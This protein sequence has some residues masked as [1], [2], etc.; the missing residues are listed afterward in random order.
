[1]T[2]EE[3]DS[4]VTATIQPSTE[5]TLVETYETGSPASATVTVAN[6]D[7][8]N[9]E[10]R[11]LE[12]RGVSAPH[13][14]GHGIECSQ[15]VGSSHVRTPE[16]M[17][18]RG[19][20]PVGIKQPEVGDIIA[21]EGLPSDWVINV[22]GEKVDAAV[23]TVTAG[24]SPVTEGTNVMFTVTR[25]TAAATHLS[26]TVGVAETQRMIFNGVP[27]GIDSVRWPTRVDILA[28]ATDA[29]FLVVTDDD[30]VD[31]ADSVI[32]ATV[33]AGNGYTVGTSGSAYRL[34]ADVDTALE[35]Q[36]LDLSQRQ[37][38]ADI[39]HHREADDFGRTVEVAEG[40]SHL[41]KLWM[42]HLR[43]NPFLSD[44]A[45]APPRSS[46]KRPR[47][48][49]EPA[50]RGA[51]HAMARGPAMACNQRANPGRAVLPV[52]R[53][54]RHARSDR[55]GTRERD[56]GNPPLHLD[57]RPR[58][59]HEVGGNRTRHGNRRSRRRGS[60]GLSGSIPALRRDGCVTVMRP[61]SSSPVTAEPT[62]S[63][64]CALWH[65]GALPDQARA[66]C[67]QHVLL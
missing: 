30:D 54:G 34:M 65:E 10:R 7:V 21:M 27:A 62:G 51:R 24:T 29:T 9:F 3:R 40:I 58:C 37:W 52:R 23:V 5:T 50:A 16:E 15:L 4:V 63:R 42:P 46:G 25:A 8:G 44:N 12:S 45:L 31:E 61:P 22:L 67:Q 13:S 55:G 28:N 64:S 49:G 60:V 33:N 57:D 48:H 47:D 32:T 38:V 43:I 36:I 18:A 1:M 2:G 59:A 39:H 35:Q 53:A 14:S 66:R 6:D 56:R 41:A 20:A 19:Y 17:T 26:V 11:R